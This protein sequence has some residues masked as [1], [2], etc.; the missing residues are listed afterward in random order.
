MKTVCFPEE[1]RLERL[2]KAHSRRQFAC[3]D[4]NVDVWLQQYALQNQEKH[5]STTSVLID[6]SNTIVGYFTL[7]AGQ[8]L[9]DELPQHLTSRL[10]KRG[11]P[12]A[13]LA[14]LGV[15]TEF[16]G[17]GFGHRLL[18]QALNDCYRASKT[19]AFIGIIVDCLDQRTKAFY[20]Q[21]DFEELKP[22]SLRLFLSCEKLERLMN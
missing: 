4:C 7:A 16:Q 14:W 12:V 5:L 3:G 6:A 17:Q 9:C 10:P 20:C 2:T 11:L 15:A 13:V 19:L 8:V 1:F 18:A 21:W 22:A